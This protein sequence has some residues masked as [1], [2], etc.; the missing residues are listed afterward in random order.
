MKKLGWLLLV[1]TVL[2]SAG[3]LFLY[4]YRWEWHRALFAAAAFIAAEIALAAA[5]IMRQLGQRPAEPAR[6]V[7]PAPDPA[8]LARLREAA[9]R[10]DPFAWMRTTSERTNVFIT[11]VLGGGVLVSA[12]TW[13]L[14][15]VASRTAG[16]ALERNLARRLSAL[17][18]PEGG[19]IADDAEVLAQEVPYAEDPELRL[20]LGPS[21]APRRPPGPSR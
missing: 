20:L 12:A 9:P 3:Y 8:V 21:R 2:G 19:L 15:R 16:P 4:L 18:F 5:L 1:L 6:V 11:M 10:R 14:D 17:A 7:A 13:L